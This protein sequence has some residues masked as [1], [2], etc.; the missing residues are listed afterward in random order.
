MRRT[1]KL[2]LC[3]L[4]V[5]ATL[6]GCSGRH[7]L[8][9]LAV[10]EGMSIDRAAN[11]V[12]VSVQTLNMT[13]SGNGS[14]ALSGNITINTA[15]SGTGISQALSKLSKDLSRNL[16]LGQ[17]KITVF[18]S[19]VARHGVGDNMD[20]FVRSAASRPDVLLCVADGNAK[21]LLQSKEDDALVPS[22]NMVH[23]LQ[24]GQDSGMG[25]VVS[26]ND[27]LRRFASP[28]SDIYLP[29]LKRVDTH[30]AFVGLALFDGGKMTA[31]ADMDD[32]FGIL[33]MNGKI[34]SGL[35]TLQNDK[36]GH[37]GVELVSCKVRARSAMENGRTVFRVTVQ[38]Q[39]M[40]DEVQKGYI[41]TIDNRSIAVIERLAEQKLV[42]LCTGAYACLQAA[43]CDGVQVGARLAMSDPAGY[44]AVKADWN[45]AFSASVIQAVCH[46]RITK[47]NDNS[48]RE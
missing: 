32:T 45:R 44:A 6:C 3:F 48:I 36:L 9:N 10:V 8:S 14:E 34:K 13:K 11:G 38:A 29:L 1:I 30:T 16:F 27:A 37:I 31:T 21:A 33:L 41:S 43:G 24:N 46:C 40:L 25:A 15:E 22:A 19:S 17:N 23:L 5:A 20:Y 35:L 7:T 12:S 47:I 4:L 42:D 28:T 18:S 2:L 39:L 26:V